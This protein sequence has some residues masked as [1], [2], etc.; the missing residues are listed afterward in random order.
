[1]KKYE[2]PVLTAFSLSGNETLCSGCGDFPLKYDDLG[3]LYAASWGVEKGAN[4]IYDNKDFEHV[5]V[6]V[7]DSCATIVDYVGG[8]KFT[9]EGMTVIWS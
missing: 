5:F 8:C 3:E 4:G 1:M 2:K 7:E 9:L 6:N